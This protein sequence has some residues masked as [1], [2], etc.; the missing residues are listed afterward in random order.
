MTHAFGPLLSITRA[1]RQ[2]NWVVQVWTQQ[3]PM[4]TTSHINIEFRNQAKTLPLRFWL[5]WINTVSTTLNTVGVKTEISRPEKINTVQTFA[6]GVFGWSW[7]FNWTVIVDI[8]FLFRPFWFTRKG[9]IWLSGLHDP[10][11]DPRFYHPQLQIPRTSRH[12]THERLLTS[13]C[14]VMFHLLA[15]STKCDWQL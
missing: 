15:F 8:F 9:Q 1:V 4:R 3:M 2:T 6:R 12:T 10:V 11:S 5:W 14:F 13:P 7:P